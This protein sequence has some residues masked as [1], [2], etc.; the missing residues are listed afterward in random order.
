M[1]WGVSVSN[2]MNQDKRGKC[3]IVVLLFSQYHF[4][5]K[6]DTTAFNSIIILHAYL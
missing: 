3:T 6:I 4:Q 5:N 1:V 2:L